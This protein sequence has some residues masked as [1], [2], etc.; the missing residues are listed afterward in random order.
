[1]VNKFDAAKPEPKPKSGNVDIWPLVIADIEDRVKMGQAKYGTVLQA[2]NG[3]DSLMDAYQ[4]AIDL[5]LYLRQ[6]IEEKRQGQL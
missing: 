5:V 1:M 3:R 2:N 6:A 4:E